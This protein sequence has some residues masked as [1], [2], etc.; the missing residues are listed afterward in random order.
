M[1]LEIVVDLVFV[2]LYEN[3][4]RLLLTLFNYGSR[5]S[6]DDL[7]AGDRMYYYRPGCDDAFITDVCH[8]NC[9]IADPRVLSDADFSQR[10]T[11][12]AYR[13]ICTGNGVLLFATQYMDA[14]TEQTIRANFAATNIALWSN[15]SAGSYLGIEL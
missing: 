8:D 3:L 15:I 1:V 12:I 9:T 4:F 13:N 11:L 10:A 7:V 2:G 14:A 5:V 6:S